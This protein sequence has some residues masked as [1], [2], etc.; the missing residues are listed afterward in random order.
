MGAL[1]GADR[2]LVLGVTKDGEF[3]PALEISYPTVGT[4]QTPSPLVRIFGD[5]RIDGIIKSND[6]RTRTVTEEV[7]A[8][9]TGMVQ[10]GQATGSS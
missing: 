9:L 3:Q 2:R 5:L 8:L 4:S 7:A 6:V 1:S 10:A